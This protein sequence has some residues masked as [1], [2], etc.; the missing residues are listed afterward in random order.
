MK[1]DKN[2]TTLI[3]SVLFILLGGSFLL[4]TSGFLSS[5]GRLWPVPLILL[6]LFLLYVTFFKGGPDIYIF[7]GVIISLVGI[8]VILKERFLSE[9][10]LGM[11]WPVFMM[12]T[13]IAFFPYAGRKRGYRRLSFIISG[14]TVI[15]LA[16]SFLPFSLG[17]TNRS[18]TG[19]VS[20]WWPVL[21]IILGIILL[22]VYIGG[23][24]LDKK[25]NNHHQ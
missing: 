13:G 21:I 1:N 15:L 8:F 12:I 4:W 3:L 14:I 17:L 7:P 2:N 10:T 16:V 5:F 23:R 18:L 22:V 6:G 11:I 24:Y 19:F 9:S 25:G 20:L